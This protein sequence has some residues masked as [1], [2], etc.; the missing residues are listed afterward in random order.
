M[1]PEFK[2]FFAKTKELSLEV[3]PLTMKPILQLMR[4]Q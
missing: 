4:K 2:E 1:L 3:T